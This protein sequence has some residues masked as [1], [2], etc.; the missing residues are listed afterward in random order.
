MLSR[1]AKHVT[2]R[3]AMS[4]SSD[5]AAPP[6]DGVVDSMGNVWSVSPDGSVAVA[7]GAMSPSPARPATQV[8]PP[9]DWSPGEAG[10][11]CDGAGYMWLTNGSQHW[12]A[13][14][15]TGGALAF[16]SAGQPIVWEGGLDRPDPVAHPGWHPG[17]R[18]PFGNHDIHACECEGKV[19]VSGGLAPGGF[20]AEYRVFDEMFAWD[21]GDDSE[22]ELV[23]RM[24]VR[25]TFNGL[26][27]LEGEIW[28]CGGADGAEGHAGTPDD[29]IPRTECF[30]WTPP[31]AG[32]RRSFSLACQPVCSLG[33]CDSLAL[34]SCTGSLVL[35]R[36]LPRAAGA[37]ALRSTWPA[38]NASPSAWLAGSGHSVVRA[39]RRGENHTTPSNR[40][41]R[42]RLRGALRAHVCQ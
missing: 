8:R 11:A 35:G 20:P 3:A 13:D 28:V 42:A 7:A 22:W 14:P 25:R 36:A 10:L 24:P 37:R 38:L 16:G 33:L 6:A 1:V 26:A 18:L 17:P 21:G 5:V 40:S 39:I 31:P 4:I 2:C 41:D 29:R 19:Y 27:C 9:P 30:I 32:V 15:R 23:C 12:R 34:T